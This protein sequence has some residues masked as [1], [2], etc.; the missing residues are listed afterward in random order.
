MSPDLKPHFTRT[1][2]IRWGSFEKNCQLL[3][4]SWRSQFEIMWFVYLALLLVQLNGSLA[5]FNCPASFGL[6]TNPAKCSSYFECENFMPTTKECGPGLFFNEDKK[7][8]DWPA[9]VDQSRCSGSNGG[10]N[11]NSN[12]GLNSNNKPDYSNNI[13]HSNHIGKFST[14]LP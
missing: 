11:A 1:G 6:F 5:A 13:H 9:S 12:N 8:C 2:I 3:T 14:I 4:V 7:N 10:I